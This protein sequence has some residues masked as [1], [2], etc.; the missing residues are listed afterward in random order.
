VIDEVSHNAMS[1]HPGSTVQQ[2]TTTECMSCKGTNITGASYKPDQITAGKGSY[3]AVGTAVSIFNKNVIFHGHFTE[4][5]TKCFGHTTRLLSKL[6]HF[7]MLDK[8]FGKSCLPR[9]IHSE[10]GNKVLYAN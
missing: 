3:V 5:T 6:F 8:G 4:Y 1:L 2:N 7:L 10:S 9:V